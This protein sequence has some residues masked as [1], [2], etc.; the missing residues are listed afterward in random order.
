MARVFDQLILYAAMM[1][2]HVNLSDD[3]SQEIHNFCDLF[4]IKETADINEFNRFIRNDN[5]RTILGLTVV[6]KSATVDKH[7]I[8]NV[9][10]FKGY[11]KTQVDEHDIDNGNDEV[12]A[13]KERR[14]SKKADLSDNY[15]ETCYYTNV[16]KKLD[17]VHNT[18]IR[19][20]HYFRPVH[21]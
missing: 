2:K 16:A 13:P 12:H 15:I 17:S 14:I 11:L 1:K 5:I 18:I 6:K 20:S 21:G 19:S 4:D 3:R 10:T 7:L 8:I 9:G